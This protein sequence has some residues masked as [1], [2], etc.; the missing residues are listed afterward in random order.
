VSRSLVYGL[1]AWSQQ[2]HQQ[3]CWTGLR[4]VTPESSSGEIAARLDV[5]ESTV[6]ANVEGIIASL[7]DAE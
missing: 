1:F 2:V 6:T 7:G 3:S 4:L 5:P